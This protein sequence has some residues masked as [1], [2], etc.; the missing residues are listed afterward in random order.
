MN[1]MFN[2][3]ERR[4]GIMVTPSFPRFLR[5]SWF[6][7]LITAALIVA[8]C[9]STPTKPTGEKDF[10]GIY[11]DENKS[12]DL[13]VRQDFDAAIKLLQDGQYEKGIELLEKVK[14]GSQNNSA[15]YINIA[16]AYVMIGNL[17][18]AEENLKQALAINP[19]HPVANN[20]YALLHRKTGRYA[21]ARQLYEKVVN[22][23]PE[24]MPARK[25]LGILCEL[26]LDD[27]PCALA[28]YEEYSEANPD[29]EDVKLWITGLRQ[30]LGN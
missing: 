3:L 15:P 30:K 16:M 17:D 24:Y 26:Y 29:D 22:K 12:V 8:G 9:V 23:Y 1:L 4:V 20:E 14:K 21:E 18:R 10:E 25:N 11:F 2:L 13:S 19:E 7:G 28:Q 6:A 5:L 27:M